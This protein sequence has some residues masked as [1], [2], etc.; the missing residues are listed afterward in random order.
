MATR[1]KFI[2]CVCSEDYYDTS[3]RKPLVLRCSHSVCKQCLLQMQ[4]SSNKQCP[5][6]TCRWADTSV[7]KLVF[8]FDLVLEQATTRLEADTE[9][10]HSEAKSCKH[11]DYDFEFRCKTCEV[12]SCMQ[13]L[14]NDHF[15]CDFGSIVYVLDD[16]LKETKEQIISAKSEVTKEITKAI[17]ETQRRLF[18][19]GGAIKGLHMQEAKLVEFD[20]V[21]SEFLNATLNE[22]SEIEK[23]SLVNNDITKV[24]EAIDTIKDLGATSP[25]EHLPLSELDTDTISTLTLLAA[26]KQER[27]KVFVCHGLVIH[28]L[29]QYCRL[30]IAYV[31]FCYASTSK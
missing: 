19:I 21:L 6:C 12:P 23:T 25:P 11:H 26:N 20:T 18:N 14:K 31:I 30:C 29:S 22:L 16:V 10:R 24:M 4:T 2:R 1:D 8:Y 7:D 9:P 13:C 5:K 27:N 17:T 15:E 3:D 28:S